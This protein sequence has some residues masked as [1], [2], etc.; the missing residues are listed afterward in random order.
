MVSTDPVGMTVLKGSLSF[1]SSHLYTLY[2]YSACDKPG[3]TAMFKF[4][5]TLNFLASSLYFFSVC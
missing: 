1:A 5:F 4:L 2:H 3:K